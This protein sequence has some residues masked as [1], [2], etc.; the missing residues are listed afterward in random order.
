MMSNPN[1][2]RFDPRWL[3]TPIKTDG[4]QLFG[5][6][7]VDHRPEATESTNDPAGQTFDEALEQIVSD[8]WRSLSSVWCDPGPRPNCSELENHPTPDSAQF[9]RESNDDNARFITMAVASR[10]RVR[11]TGDD[12][13][14]AGRW[15]R[16]L[17]L[18]P[19]QIPLRQPGCGPVCQARDPSPEFM[20]N[21]V[22]TWR[23]VPA[24]S[25][26]WGWPR[27]WRRSRCSSICSW[28]SARAS[29]RCSSAPGPSRWP[30]PPR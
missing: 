18:G 16:L 4:E 30:R 21:F 26:W 13:D 10:G 11:P 5:T 2:G 15:G 9:S 1:S 6:L 14:P 27:G 29:C 28:Q 20:A 23:S 22:G 24:S 7:D 12:L 3:S 8:E 19:D 25:S 17:S